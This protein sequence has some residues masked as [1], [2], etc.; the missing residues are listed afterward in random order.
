MK[1]RS[2]GTSVVRADYVCSGTKI[3]ELSGEELVKLQQLMKYQLSQGKKK[4]LADYPVKL[5]EIDDNSKLSDAAIDNPIDSKPRSPLCF[6]FFFYF[7]HERL[8]RF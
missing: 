8:L 7:P 2:D 6:L 4:L 1:L 5:S 3:L